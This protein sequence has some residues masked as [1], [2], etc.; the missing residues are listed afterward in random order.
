VPNPPWCYELLFD[1]TVRFQKPSGGKTVDL[2]WKFIS[3]DEVIDEV[4]KELKRT[5]DENE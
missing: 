5:S 1:S 4:L 3:S 2:T